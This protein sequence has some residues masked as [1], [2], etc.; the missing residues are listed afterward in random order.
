MNWNRRAWWIGWPVVLTVI[1][2]WIG[3]VLGSVAPIFVSYAILL[4]NTGFIV[5][6]ATSIPPTYDDSETPTQR[7]RRGRLTALL[8]FSLG[9]LL[10]VLLIGSCF[11]FIFS[12]RSH[13]SSGPH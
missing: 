13:L 7:K 5:F 8:T 12:L 10:P 2:T 9:L 11:W 6:F 3:L 1:G 4:G